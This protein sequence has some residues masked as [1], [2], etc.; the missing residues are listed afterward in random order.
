MYIPRQ[1]T[2]CF[3]SR[4]NFL[5]NSFVTCQ[6]HPSAS[7]V[8]TDVVMECA[9]PS[10][11][12]QCSVHVPNSFLE[13]GVAEL[14]FQVWSLPPTSNQ[15]HLQGRTPIALRSLLCVIKF[16]CL[17]GEV[18][19]V[20]IGRAL[21]DLGPLLY[22]LTQI[23]GWYHIIDFGGRIRGQIKVSDVLENFRQESSGCNPEHNCG[24][25]VAVTP[26]NKKAFQRAD[27]CLDFLTLNSGSTEDLSLYS[28]LRCSC[29]CFS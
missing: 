28:K 18:K 12:H 5:P 4:E 7:K 6:P 9:S 23:C 20:F 21:V 11:E 22:G 29:W 3:C 15:D 25:Q 27:G 13:S 24:L 10:W 8:V 1:C 26:R 17:L 2:V 16:Y 19:H 14:E